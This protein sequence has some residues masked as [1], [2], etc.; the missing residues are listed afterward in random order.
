[1]NN[2]RIAGFLKI[3]MIWIIVMT[4]LTGIY[5]ASG[6]G[7]TLLIGVI[8]S[9]LVAGAMYVQDKQLK[10]IWNDNN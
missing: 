2:Y 4:A 9:W 7:L 5:A 6:S 8:F 10:K 3:L 1:M